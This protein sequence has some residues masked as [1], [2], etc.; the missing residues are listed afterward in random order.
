MSHSIILYHDQY[1]IIKNTL[2]NYRFEQPDME[3]SVCV[4][5]IRFR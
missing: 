5:K 4:D 3:Y 2:S 1:S